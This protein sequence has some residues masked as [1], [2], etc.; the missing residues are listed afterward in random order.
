M[1]Y[2]CESLEGAIKFDPKK[3]NSWYANFTDGYFTCHTQS[4][5]DDVSVAKFHKTEFYD[6]QGRRLSKLQSGVNIVKG[7]NGTS[8]VILRVR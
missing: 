3:I 5:I 2:G 8:K 7:V 1:F 6:L 4:G